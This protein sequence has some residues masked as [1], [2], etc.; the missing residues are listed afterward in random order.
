MK[1]LY[2]LIA[3]AIVLVAAVATFAHA[4]YYSP[5]CYGTL[6]NGTFH[7]HRPVANAYVYIAENHAFHT[8]TDA[9][10]NFTIPGADPGLGTGTYHVVLDGWCQPIAFYYAQNPVNIG[11][12]VGMPQ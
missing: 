5:I 12:I 11:T 9:N 4:T 1:K 6:L 10:G 7:P 2:L 8:Y 3:V